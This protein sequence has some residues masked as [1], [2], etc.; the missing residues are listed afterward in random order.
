[1]DRSRRDGEKLPPAASRLTVKPRRGNNRKKTQP[2]SLWARLPK[3]ALIADACSRVLRR[4]VPALIALAILGTLGGTAWAG[5]RFVTHSQRFAITT[6]D[7][8]GNRQV[9]RSEERRVGKEC[10]SRW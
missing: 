2:G 1:M 9:T 3:P 10:R 6:I 8:S 4:S 7:V 5:Y